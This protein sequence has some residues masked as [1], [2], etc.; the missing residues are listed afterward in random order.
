MRHT[1]PRLSIRLSAVGKDLL[2]QL[3]ETLGLTQTGALEVCI[4][5]KAHSLGLRP[6]PRTPQDRTQAPVG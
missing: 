4:R 1:K 2:V 5:E 6:T 3:S